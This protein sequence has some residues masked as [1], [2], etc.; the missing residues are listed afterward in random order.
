MIPN[1]AVISHPIHSPSHNTNIMGVLDRLMSFSLFRLRSL[2]G[3]LKK[4]ASGVL[5]LVPCSR[6]AGTLRA[7]KGL[8][9]CWTDS[10][11]PRGQAF[12]TFPPVHDGGLLTR[13]YEPSA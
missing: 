4:A 5:A 8:R 6:T 9:P 13:M 2:L 10:P 3:M 7:P 12:G 11:P 1:Q